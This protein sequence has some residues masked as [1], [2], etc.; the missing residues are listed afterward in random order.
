MIHINPEW[1]TRPGLQEVL[2][3][4]FSSADGESFVVGGCVR[5]A[6][7]GRVVSDVDIATP[8]TPD[9]VKERMDELDATV[10]DTGLQHGTV[11][12]SHMGEHYEVTTFRADVSTDGRH[13]EVEFITDM[14]ED[15]LRR[16]FTMNALY[17]DGFGRV[18]DPTG[19]GV[20]DL[21][22]RCVRFVGDAGERLDEDLLRMMRLFRFHAVLGTGAMNK[23]ALDAVNRRASGISRVSKERIWVELKKLLDAHD[24][25]DAVMEM[26]NTGLLFALFKDT[27]LEDF[28]ALLYHE[29][30]LSLTPSWSRRLVGLAEFSDEAIADTMMLANEDKRRISAT[31]AATKQLS[32]HL[33]LEHTAYHFG[34]RIGMDAVALTRTDGVDIK[35]SRTEL[36]RLAS[37][38]GAKIFPATGQDLIDLG[39]TPGPAIGRALKD[40][41][42]TWVLNSFEGTREEMLDG[43]DR[44]E[45]YYGEHSHDDH[46]VGAHTAC[47]FGDSTG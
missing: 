2:A 37:H 28:G 30:K 15:A 6:L 36:W 44:M 13:A 45:H 41:E 38:A 26:A 14:M 25:M 20:A 31:R 27:H 3:N 19:Q 46:G 32:R 21:A 33:D 8:L 11:T 10:Y 17:A 7:I 43:M 12:V 39:W 4:L 18:F 35:G 24:P 5:D 9:E 40:M 29:K 22:A 42:I 47:S 16:D 23:E 34:A 1:L